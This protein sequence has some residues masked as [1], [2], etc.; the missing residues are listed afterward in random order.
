MADDLSKRL[1]KA[2]EESRREE[3]SLR[4]ASPKNNGPIT[5]SENFGNAAA[6]LD[7]MAELAEKVEALEQGR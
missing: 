5:R 7:L 2:A 4:H 3:R 6:M 1:R